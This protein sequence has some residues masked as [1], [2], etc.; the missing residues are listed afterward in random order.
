M[1]PWD[2]ACD[3]SRQ[4][5]LSLDLA[6]RFEPA[7]KLGPLLAAG[8]AR[9]G[10]LVPR[11][12]GSLAHAWRPRVHGSFLLAPKAKG[13]CGRDE[14]RRGCRAPWAPGGC[15]CAWGPSAFGSWPLLGVL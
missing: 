4:G 12:Q 15:R 13:S 3:C 11:A 9:H 1:S 10:C 7:P 5:P 14:W 2:P 6:G 8:G